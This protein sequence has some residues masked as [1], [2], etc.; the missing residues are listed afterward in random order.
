MD[1]LIGALVFVSVFAAVQFVWSAIAGSRS[2]QRAR[3]RKRLAR[4][5][6]RLPAAESEARLTLLREEAGD[7]PGAIARWTSPT[8][9]RFGVR[10]ATYVS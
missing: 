6:L 10:A 4:L 3:L 5:G 9:S 7:E 8:W 2:R 1:P